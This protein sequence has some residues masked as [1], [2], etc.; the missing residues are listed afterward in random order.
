[1]RNDIHIVSI[2]QDFFQI[3]EKK[4]IFPKIELKI[5]G[6]HILYDAKIAFVVGK[7]V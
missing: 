3:N 6:K 1:V 7:I 5:P 4:Y 2:Y